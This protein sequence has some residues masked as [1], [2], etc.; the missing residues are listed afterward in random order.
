MTRRC[1]VRALLAIFVATLLVVHSAPALADESSLRERY[2]NE[3]TPTPTPEQE[4]G[5]GTSLT[6][7][8]TPP[9]NA[10]AAPVVV[11]P[12][13]EESAPAINSG[14]TSFASAEAMISGNQRRTGSSSRG[15]FGTRLPALAAGLS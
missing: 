15:I 10:N 8:E 13:V 11:L 1:S 7:K 9:E 2:P 3:V 6:S 5:D 4:L 12:T 14:G